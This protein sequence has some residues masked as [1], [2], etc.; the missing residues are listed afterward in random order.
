MLGD[1][2]AAIERHAESIVEKENSKDFTVDT[3]YEIPGLFHVTRIKRAHQYVFCM[4]TFGI[5]D[6]VIDS[7]NVRL[8]NN[9][10][11]LI[12]DKMA[13]RF[14]ARAVAMR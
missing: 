2:M 8:K 5:D 9:D 1:F 4:F 10:M 7:E 6:G 13:A 14:H 3:T 11:E 12:Y